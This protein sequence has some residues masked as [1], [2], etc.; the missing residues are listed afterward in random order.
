MDKSPQ[1]PPAT[2]GF[3]L[4]SLL[5]PL[6]PVDRLAYSADDA[7][8]AVGVSRRTIDRMVAAGDLRAVNLRNRK[9]IPRGEL[10]RVLGAGVNR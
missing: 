5:R 1:T 3:D 8:R 2:T 4:G 10:E 6:P 7:A 9:V